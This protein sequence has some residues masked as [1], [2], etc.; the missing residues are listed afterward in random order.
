MKQKVFSSPSQ[1]IAII[2]YYNYN[3]NFFLANSTI[4]LPFK[5]EYILS[6]TVITQAVT[7]SLMV[8]WIKGPVFHILKIFQ[9]YMGHHL[10]TARQ[11]IVCLSTFANESTAKQETWETSWHFKGLLISSSRPRQPPKNQ[12][13]GAR[14]RPSRRTTSSRSP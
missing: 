12:S 11:P 7:L 9:I 8:I 3:N 4:K 1:K 13:C 5:I 14:K 6:Q 10:A 2:I